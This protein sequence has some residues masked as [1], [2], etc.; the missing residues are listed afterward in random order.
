MVKLGGELAEVVRKELD[1]K[2][3]KVNEFTE[4]ELRKVKQIRISKKD[5]PLLEYFPN[6][7]ILD[8]DIF[9]SINDED[10]LVISNYLPNIASLKIKEQNDLYELDFSTFTN[11]KELALIHNDNL[12]SFKIVKLLDRFTFYDNKDFNRCD[13]IVSYLISNP[14]AKVTLDIAHYIDVAR[15][16][17]RLHEDASVLERITWVECSGL[18]KYVI[19]QFLNSEVESMMG[20]VSSIAS[21]YLYVSDGE[22]EKFGVLYRWM[23]RNVSFVNEDEPKGE[24]V[25]NINNIYKVFNFRKG[26]RLS[27]AKAFQI[28]LSYAGIE[29]SVVY[30]YGA[31]DTIGYYN[32][33]KVYSLLGDSDYALLRVKLDG[34]YYYCDV[35]W[36]SMV[37]NLRYF[38]ELRLLLISKDELRLRHK[39]VGESEITKSYSYRGDDSD[40]L[41]MFADSRIEEVDKLFNDIERLDPSI[42]GLKMES[43]LIKAKM[44]Q[45]KQEKNEPNSNE[46]TISAEIEELNHQLD[47][48]QAEL[49]RMNNFKQGI[50]DNYAQVL[51]SRYL[52]NQQYSNEDIKKDLDNRKALFLIS[53]YVY[54]ILSKIL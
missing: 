9:P 51:K 37:S 2:D 26:G 54:T 33:K 6:V 5:I 15:L 39:L 20:A 16:L 8:L 50:Y 35:T 12:R 24:N 52:Y 1:I 7:K 42:Y 19:H 40:D 18:R 36:D 3:K 21:K 34:R 32:G 41:I 47:E 30:S 25:S 38:D 13:Q 23:I 11:L 31:L 28:L 27:Y 49:Y 22:V 10:L 43:E 17:Y 4:E 14:D 46:K 45:L 53:D 48:D 44:K 29:S